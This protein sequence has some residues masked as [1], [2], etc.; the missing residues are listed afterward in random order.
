MKEV[1]DEELPL[2]EISKEFYDDTNYKSELIISN[3]TI[4][5]TK[6]FNLLN[7]VMFKIFFGLDIK[8][9]RGR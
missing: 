4:R 7:R 5:L 1:K 3:I 9:I 2:I 8:N 6:K